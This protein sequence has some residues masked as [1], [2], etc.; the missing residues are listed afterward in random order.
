MDHALLLSNVKYGQMRVDLRQV[1]W[2]ELFLNLN[3]S[4]K[5]LLF[6]DVFLEIMRNDILNK[7]IICNY[8]DAAWITPEVK[9]AF[10]RNS[11]VYKKRVRRGRMLGELDKVREVTNA[12]NKFIRRA[13]STDYNNL[14]LNLS[15]PNTGQKYFWTTYKRLIINKSTLI[16]LH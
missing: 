12:T 15:D 4:E 3:A 1:N 11:R 2:H 9:T 13:K 14:G 6:T 7:I 8:K 5:Y 10:K 16:F